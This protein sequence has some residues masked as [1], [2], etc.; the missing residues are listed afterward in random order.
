MKHSLSL[1]TATFLLG[2]ATHLFAASSVDLAV[3]GIITPAAC[4]PSLSGGGVVDHGKISI[5]DLPNNFKNPLPE[6]TL[7]L[8]VVCDAATLIALKSTDNR[9]GTAWFNGYV[10]ASYFGLGMTADNWM[11]GAYSL[12]MKNTTVEGAAVPVVESVGGATWFP[13]YGGFWQP[14]WMR[15]VA[16]PNSPD[17]LPVAIQNLTTDVVIATFVRK[18]LKLTEDLPLDGSATMDI[19]YL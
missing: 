9:E 1:I 8:T 16:A 13:V 11:P 18:P 10:T 4:T 14:G 17:N 19:V 2:G 7:Q 15:A 6:A 3:K 12:V 5:Q